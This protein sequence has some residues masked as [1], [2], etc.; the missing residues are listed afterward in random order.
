MVLERFER[1][2]PVRLKTEGAFHT[3]YM[4]EAAQH[5]RSVLEAAEFDP[6][7]VRVLSNFGGGYHRPDPADIRAGLFFQLFHPVLWYSNL[8]TAFADGIKT[9]IEFGGGIG[10]ASEPENKRPNLESMTRKTLRAN[11]HEALYLAAINSQSVKAAA[12]NVNSAV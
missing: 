2:R 1:K 6:S 9:I 11:D 5:F 10:N 4:V 3:Y 7:A 8:Q 12:D